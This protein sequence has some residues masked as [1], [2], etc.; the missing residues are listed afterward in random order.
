MLRLFPRGTPKINIT[1]F[2]HT[3][4]CKTGDGGRGK[5]FPARPSARG[6]IGGPK[7]KRV[8]GVAK[9]FRRARPPSVGL[10]SVAGTGWPD[11]SSRHATPLQARRAAGGRSHLRHGA[12]AQAADMARFRRNVAGQASTAGRIAGRT[13]NGCAG[14]GHIRREIAGRTLAADGWHGLAWAGTGRDRPR[15]GAA[16]R[17]TLPARR[18]AP[19]SLRRNLM[20]SVPPHSAPQGA[21]ARRARGGCME[22]PRRA[23]R[24]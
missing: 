23:P 21:P 19:C 7:R 8:G 24:R 9:I 20:P 13:A 17:R 6:S 14:G 10:P 16:G 4:L 11:A 5:I 3:T 1:Y 15:E 2:C 22:V 18:P 12:R